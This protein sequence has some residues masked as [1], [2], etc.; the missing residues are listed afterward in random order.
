MLP[1]HLSYDAPWPV[2]KVPLRCTPHMVTYHLESK[3]YCLVTSSSE[4]SNQYY[5]F[6]GEDKEHSVEERD[7]RFPL[8]M[9][10]RFSIM[11]FSPVSWEVSSTYS[12]EFSFACYLY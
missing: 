12:I 4:P 3:T 9:Q 6:N 10:D 5:R 1:T 7:E 8:P 11:L 2:R